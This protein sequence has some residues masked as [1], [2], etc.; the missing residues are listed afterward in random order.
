MLIACKTIMLD[1]YG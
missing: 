1:W